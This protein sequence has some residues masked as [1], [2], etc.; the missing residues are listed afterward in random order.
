MEAWAGSLP[1]L[2]HIG[3][4]VHVDSRGS[5]QELWRATGYTAIGL[6][7]CFVQDNVSRS[8]R[9]AL[10][11]LH[12]QV[13]PHAQGKLV[14]AVSGSVYD[15]A[16]DLRPDSATF[17]RWEAITLHGGDGMAVYLPPGLA[18]GFLA[19]TEETVVLYKCT[20]EYMPEA[21]AGIRWD[22]PDLGIAWPF[23]PSLVSARDAALPAF[24]EAFPGG[25]P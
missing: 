23:A 20:A 7:S 2:I 22:D 16:V 15:V 19:L 9:G 6:D 13:A 18:H 24:R 17:G 11:G 10:R 12:Y 14:M 4:K 1:G 5:F 8:G 3:T 21:E 25:A